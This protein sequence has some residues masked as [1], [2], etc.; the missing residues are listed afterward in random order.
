MTWDKLGAM[1]VVLLSMPA[2]VSAD[3]RAKTQ[4]GRELIIRDD[5]TWVYAD[6]IKKAREFQKDNAA[7]LQYTGKRGTFV[8]HLVPG[9]WTQ[10][11]S[12]NAAV[13]VAFSL[14]DNYAWATVV[15][16]RV[17]ITPEALKRVGREH[18]RKV[19]KD[20]KIVQEEKRVVNGREVLCLT[21]DLE[22]HGVPLTLHGYYYSGEEGTF[23]VLTGTAQN[24]FQELKPKLEAFLNGFEILK[25]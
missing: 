8:L 5:G 3:Q 17:R 24:L 23:Q 4:D 1:L 15:A 11:A 13:E 16:D 18:A 6:E 10:D 21:H 12:R 22:S 2:L 14:K 25:K 20:A 19:D 7:V 9:V